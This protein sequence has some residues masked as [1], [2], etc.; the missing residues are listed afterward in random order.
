MMLARGRAAGMVLPKRRLAMILP[1]LRVIL[2]AAFV[3]SGSW[4]TDSP[5]AFAD[6]LEGRLRLCFVRTGMS[7]EE[8]EACLGRPDGGRFGFG[9][10]YQDL[11]YDRYGLCI[12]IHPQRG[13]LPATA[14]KVSVVPSNS[15]GP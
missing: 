14:V 11:L 6:W 5:P 8:V 9:P 7:R 10:G 15:A 4:T 3:P 1:L 2:F 13:A 12:S